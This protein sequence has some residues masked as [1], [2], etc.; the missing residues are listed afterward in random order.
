MNYRTHRAFLEVVQGGGVSW[1]AEIHF[2]EKLPITEAK[3]AP[4]QLSTYVREELTELERVRDE[5]DAEPVQKSWL[6]FPELAQLLEK[7]PADSANLE[8]VRATTAAMKALQTRPGNT[9]RLFIVG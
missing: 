9:A 4:E 5:V 7:L 1:F 3:G 6:S 2:P 8:A